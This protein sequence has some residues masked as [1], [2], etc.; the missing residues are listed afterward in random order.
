MFKGNDKVAISYIYLNYKE[1]HEQTI[2]NLIASIL[3]QMVQDRPM[4]SDSVK[5]L[6]E[7][8]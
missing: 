5:A 4:I 7:R 3:K 6:Y 2:A 1:Q 8:H